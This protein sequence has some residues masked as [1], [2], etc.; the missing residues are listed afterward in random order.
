MR[1]KTGY[2]IDN[3]DYYANQTLNN[4]NTQC[5]TEQHV[6]YFL[7]YRQHCPDSS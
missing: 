3:I 2:E 1:A 6:G 5:S 7:V 4:L